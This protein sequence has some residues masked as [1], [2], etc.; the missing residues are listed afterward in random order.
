MRS[1]HVPSQNSPM[2]SLLT[3]KKIKSPI[4]PYAIWFLLTSFTSSTTLPLAQC[5]LAFLLFLKHTK[6]SSHPGTLNSFCLVHSSSR[7]FTEL[8]SENILFQI[9]SKI[10]SLLIQ[11]S[12][13][14]S[15]PQRGSSFTFIFLN[16]ILLFLNFSCKTRNSSSSTIKSFFK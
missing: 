12:A 6:A 2:L 8:F 11:V 10:L 14:M 9:F 1:H 13:Q 4:Q 3:Q 5:S 15:F 7:I 16:S